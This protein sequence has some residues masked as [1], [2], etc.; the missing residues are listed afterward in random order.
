MLL[1]KLLGVAGVIALP[2]S[3]ASAVIFVVVSIY[4]V[5]YILN[6]PF[7]SGSR[8]LDIG[9]LIVGGYVSGTSLVA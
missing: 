2:P 8:R 7:R 6:R 5:S 3:L 1:P 9:L 4:A